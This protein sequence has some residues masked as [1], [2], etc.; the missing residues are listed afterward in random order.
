MVQLQDLMIWIPAVLLFTSNQMVF[1]KILQI[2]KFDT[3]DTSNFEIGKLLHKGTKNKK[4][5]GP[6][7][8]KLGGQIM[9]EIVRLRAKTY[10]YLKGSS[11]EDKKATSTKNVT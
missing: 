6:T 3:F 5:T 7:K 10:S 11:N 8:D 9:K 2:S 4:V 1:T